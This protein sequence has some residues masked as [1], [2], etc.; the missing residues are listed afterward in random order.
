MKRTDKEFLQDRM[1]YNPSGVENIK[2]KKLLKAK[3]GNKRGFE[4]APAER[5][6]SVIIPAMNEEVHILVNSQPF[7]QC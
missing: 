2:F 6:V 4:H 7:L 5:Y 3:S 1:A